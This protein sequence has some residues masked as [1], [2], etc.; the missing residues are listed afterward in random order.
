MR[1][2]VDGQEAVCHRAAT[3]NRNPEIVHRIGGKLMAG[4][5][6]LLQR[7]LRPIGEASLVIVCRGTGG[8]TS[9][10]VC[11]YFTEVCTLRNH[12]RWTSGEAKLFLNFRAVQAAKESG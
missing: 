4:L 1:D 3:A 7:A 8:I 9:D 5:V 2:R 6:A 10:S 12:D 11:F